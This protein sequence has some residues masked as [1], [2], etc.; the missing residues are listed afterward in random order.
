MLKQT[1]RYRAKDYTQQETP[2]RWPLW[3][4]KYTVLSARPRH[5]LREFPFLQLYRIWGINDI[6]V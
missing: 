5:W 6:H 3:I 2:S 4:S 1:R